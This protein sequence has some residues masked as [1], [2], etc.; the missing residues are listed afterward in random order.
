MSR[1]RR[2]ENLS[3]TFADAHALGWAFGVAD[4]FRVNL[5][6]R[7]D[8]RIDPEASSAKETRLGRKLQPDEKVM[9]YVWTQGVPAAYSFGRGHV[10]HD[11]PIAHTVQ[12]D[13]ALPLLRRTVVVHD[14]KADPGA[15]VEVYRAEATEEAHE[16]IEQGLEATKAGGAGWV[17]IEVLYYEDGRVV[18]KEKTTRTQAALVEMLRSG[19]DPLNAAF[20]DCRCRESSGAY[21]CLRCCRPSR[22]LETL[23]LFEGLDATASLP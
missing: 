11:P 7:Y 21:T 2:T 16:V 19:K 8:A 20:D 12:W 23:P 10:F 17:D 4:A 1:K 22:L 15:L 9:R 14:S 5:D 13:A 3:V 18:A 6:V